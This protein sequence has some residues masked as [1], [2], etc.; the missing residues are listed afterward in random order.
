MKLWRLEQA[1]YSHIH[2]FLR[3]PNTQFFNMRSPQVKRP[4]PRNVIHM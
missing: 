2:D 4:W 3:L 1:Q